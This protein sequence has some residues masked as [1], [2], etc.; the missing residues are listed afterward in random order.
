MTLRKHLNRYAEK[1]RHKLKLKK[2]HATQYNG[3]G[4]NIDL[5]RQRCQ[6]ES[7]SWWWS[8]DHQRNGGYEYWNQFY[9][10]GPRRYAKECTNSV[11]RARYRDML[12]SMTDEDVED[13]QALTGS[14]YEK[15]F[16]FLWTLY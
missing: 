14:D 12:R 10:S 6:D 7:A 11:I 16:D 1:R 13:I 4:A 9:L 15:M 5:V 3:A 2:R 8:R